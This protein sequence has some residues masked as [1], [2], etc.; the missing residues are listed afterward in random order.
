MELSADALARFSGLL[1]I[2]L[3]LTLLS[4]PGPGRRCQ[5]LEQALVALQAVLPLATVKPSVQATI[6]V[7][8]VQNA[9]QAAE[10][11]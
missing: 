10:L 11:G 7:P 8:H 5:A 3:G 1:A 2:A 4:T 6:W 9:L